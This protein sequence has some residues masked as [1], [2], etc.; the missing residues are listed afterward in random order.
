M[1]QG[2]RPILMYPVSSAS[3]WV[4]LLLGV[5][6][7]L[8]PPSESSRQAAALSVQLSSPHLPHV[9]MTGQDSSESVGII[10]YQPNS[11]RSI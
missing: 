9:K 10:N 4:G 5:A 7:L 1:E 3:A 6:V 11:A 8:P 2:S